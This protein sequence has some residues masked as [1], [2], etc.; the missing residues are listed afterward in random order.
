MDLTSQ[1]TEAING[2]LQGLVAQLLGPALATAGQ[3]VFSTP[4][5]EGIPEIA[6]TWSVVRGV[7]DALF[8]VAFL[9]IG[10]A[11][12]AHGGSDTRYSAKVLVPRLGLAAL[13][14]NVSLTL[15]GALIR[16][17]NAIVEA[18]VGGSRATPFGDLASIAPVGAVPS[19][20]TAVFVGLAAATMALLLVALYIGRDVVLLLAIVLAPL[21]L[22]AS[23]FPP[24]AELARLWARLFGAL[25]FVQVIQAVLVAVL[26]QLLRHVDWLGGSGSELIS[27]LVLVTVL[28]VL[29]QLPFVA[30]RWAFQQPA[31]WTAPLR[32]TVVAARR[33]MAA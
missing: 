8:A 13:L 5:F 29:L 32:K 30:V 16:L 15:C 22:A 7:A 6:A 33:A 18:L 12:M 4:A 28:Y 2:W 17:N 14:A 27:G 9:A 1:V 31:G 3:L 19:P 21:A 25:L 24:T 10:I 23:A 11:V 26:V 20:I